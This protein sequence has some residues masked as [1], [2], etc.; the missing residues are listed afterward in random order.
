VRRR[1]AAACVGLVLSAVCLAADDLSVQVDPSANFAVF[2]TFVMRGGKVDSPRPELDN[3]LFVKKLRTT[4]RAALT[5]R[6]LTETTVRP[7]LLVDFAVSG[8]DISLGVRSPLRGVGPQPVRYTQGT[9]AID[10]TR[11]GG[12]D[13][14]WHGVYRDDEDTGSKLVQKLPEDAKKLI[15]K[16]PRRAK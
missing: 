13:P 3:S 8:E 2:K 1:L 14:V 9:L 10:L 15:D 7:D 11:P 12:S 6:G 5:A 4:I 16:Y